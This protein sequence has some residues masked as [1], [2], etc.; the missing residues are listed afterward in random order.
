M[1]NNGNDKNNGTYNRSAY[2][3]LV[4][5]A[6]KNG[7]NFEDANFLCKKHN[8]RKKR[9]KS[10]Y[11]VNETLLN[12]AFMKEITLQDLLIEEKSKWM[13]ER[14]S[15][16]TESVKKIQELIGFIEENKDGKFENEINLLLKNLG[17]N[18]NLY[19]N[20]NKKDKKDKK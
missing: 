16:K 17:D 12:D 11:V 2:I 5:W 20:N 14:N 8:V 6:A 7:L 1:N 18:K 4:D 10:S 15:M 3:N 19:L 9:I 13:K